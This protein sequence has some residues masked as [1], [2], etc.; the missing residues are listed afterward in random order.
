[1]ARVRARVRALTPRGRC[2][3]DLRDV[4]ADLNRVL[5]GWANYFRTGNAAV[6]FTQIDTYVEERLRGLRYKR[7]GSRLRAGRADTW[8]RPFFE[9]LG[10][11]RLRGTIAYPGAA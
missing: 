6:K 9:T 2:H 1:M 4:I 10:L 3:E 8:S 7:A 5:R 11:C